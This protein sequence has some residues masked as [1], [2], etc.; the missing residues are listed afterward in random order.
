MNCS[1]STTTTT[2]ITTVITMPRVPRI[3]TPLLA[4]RHPPAGGE[5]RK[6][7]DPVG[8]RP[9]SILFYFRRFLTA[10][11]ALSMPLPEPPVRLSFLPFLSPE[12]LSLAAF[13]AASLIFLPMP[14]MS[15]TLSLKCAF[16][17]FYEVVSIFCFI[18]LRRVPRFLLRF[19]Y[20]LT[21]FN[22]SA[23]RPS[24]RSETSS[25]FISS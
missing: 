25:T 5:G 14:A 23:E 15:T 3:S 19:S 21:L 18:S 7:R 11:L 8:P 2:I 10:L 9:D 20:F 24:S 22:S 16:M 12:I 6:G 4:C 13:V 1:T 17:S